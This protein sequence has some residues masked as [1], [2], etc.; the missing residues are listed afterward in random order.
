MPAEFLNLGS[1]IE[2]VEQ[3]AG[4]HGPRAAFTFERD[5]TR[6]AAGVTYQQLRDHTAAVAARLMERGRP[7]DRV[8]ILCPPGL[9]YVHAFL[10]SLMAGRVAVPAYPPLS[11]RA[12]GRVRAQL[13]DSGA[14]VIATTRAAARAL[15]PIL[16]AWDEVR[17]VERVHIDEV[18]AS[19]ASGWQPPALER[20]D[21]AFLQYTSGSTGDPR[22]VRVTHANLL[23]NEAMIQR[24]FGTDDHDVIL[25]WLPMFHDMG[26]LGM[27][28]T[29]AVGARGVLLSPLDFLRRPAHW[30]DAATRHRATVSG[31]PNFAYD[32]CARKITEA[33]LAGLDLS[34]WRV[35]Y[36]GAEPVRAGTLA[37]FIDRFEARGLRREALLPCYGMAE[38]TLLVA[39]ARSEEAPRVIPPP[40]A[41]SPG[42]RPCVDCGPPPAG[43]RCVAVD[44]ASGRALAPGKVGELWVAGPHVADGY[45]GRAEESAITFSARLENGEAPFLRT[46][47][48][49]FL[50]DD[51]HVVVTGRA[52]E[53]MIVRGANHHP[54]D[55]EQTVERAHVALR[56][57]GGAV[58]SIEAEDEERVVVVHEIERGA[59]DEADAVIAAVRRAVTEEHGIDAYAVALVRAGSVPRTSSG[60]VRRHACREQF[61][62]GTLHEIARSVARPVAGLSGGEADRRRH[63]HDLIQDHRRAV[64]ALVAEI[65]GAALAL[66]TGA[67]HDAPL[68]SLGVDSLTAAELTGAL[69][70][71]LGVHV[72]ISTILR[73]ATARDLAQAVLQG[74]PAPAPRRVDDLPALGRLSYGQQAL[75][76]HYCAAPT[77]SAYNEVF[78]AKV[79][80]PLDRCALRRALE[81]VL[82]RH[83][84]LRVR[85]ALRDG[86]PWCEP[87]PLLPGLLREVDAAGWSAT[88]LE[89][90]I[91]EEA[92]RPFALRESP[93][94]RATVYCRA[95][96][97]WA[98]CLVVHHIAV[99]LWSFAVVVDEL[100]A[101]Y[102]ALLDGRTPALPAPTAPYHRF[103]QREEELVGSAEGQRMRAYWER[104]LTP[105]PPRLRFTQ[106]AEI[107]LAGAAR[108]RKR[109]ERWP[110]DLSA[111]ARAFARD[112]ATTPYSVLLAA[113][114][115]FLHRITG[116]T[117]LLVGSPHANRLSPDLDGTV[118][119]LVNTLPMRADLSGRPTFDEHLERTRAAA[120]EALDHQAYP[121]ALFSDRLRRPDADMTGPF[122]VLFVFQR[123][124]RLAAEGGAGFVSGAGMAMRAGGLTLEPIEVLHKDPPADL[125][126]IVIDSGDS[127]ETVVLAAPHRVAAEV[128]DRLARWF[129]TFLLGA[130]RRPD[131]PLDTIPL[132]EPD[133]ERALVPAN[134]AGSAA[135]LDRAVGELFDEAA[136]ASPHAVAITGDAEPLHYGELKRQANRLANHLVAL[137]VRAG[138]RVAVL[139]DRSP[140]M[141]IALL[142]LC[143]AG[144]AY[145]PLDRANPAPRQQAILE[146]CGATAA[147]ARQDDLAEL[148][149]GLTGIDP[150]RD[151]EVIASR[152]DRAP[153]GRVLGAQAAYVMFTSGSTGTPKGVVVPHRAI[154]RLVHETDY[155]ELGPP[156]VVMQYAPLAF[157]ASTFEIWGALLTGATLALMPRGPLTPAELSAAIARHRVTTLW[158]TAALFRQA[159]DDTTDLFRGVR[160]VL[161]GGE[162]L[163]AEHVARLLAA[164]TPGG[165]VVVNGYGPTE[166]TTFTTCHR[167]TSA[168]P[169]SRFVPIGRPIRHTAVYVLDAQLRPLPPGVV[170]EI[171]A[172]GAGLA[173]GYLGQPAAT[174]AAFV[175]NPFDPR[176]SRLYRTGDIGWIGGDGAL[177]FVG[178]RDEQIKLRGFRIELSE[179]E[180]ALRRHPAVKDAV[181]DLRRDHAEEAILVAYVR[182]A[183][184]RH[185]SE[186]E[187]RE[188]LTR[189]LPPYMVPSAIVEV[190]ELVMTR[191]GKLDRRALPPPPRRE[192]AG[193]TLATPA[194]G[195]ETEISR[196]WADVLG[197]PVG[198]ET[199]FFLAGGHSLTATRV[200]GRLAVAPG[201]DVPLRT[202]FE[203][204]TLREFA[205]RVAA[206]QGAPRRETTSIP[207]ARR[208]VRLPLSFSQRR[209]WI[210]D[211]LLPKD[212]A[213]NVPLGLRLRGRLNADALDGAL[214]D[215]VARHEALRTIF[216]E[217]HGAPLQR[218][219]PSPRALLRLEQLPGAEDEAIHAVAADEAMVGFDLASDR[220]LRARLIRVAD[221]DH[222]L[223]LTLHHIAVDGWA[224][225]LLIRDLLT[226]YRGRGAGVDAGLPPLALQIA[227]YACWE[228]S[229]EGEGTFVESLEYWQRRLEGAPHVL[230][231]PSSHPRPRHQRHRGAKRRFLV[232]PPLRR[233]LD[234]LARAEH[235]TPFMLFLTAFNV[236]LHRLTGKTD[237][238][239]GTPVAGRA[240]PEIE[241]V[242]GCFVNTLVVRTSLVGRPTFRELVRRVA[243]S[244]VEDYAHQNAP[245]DRVVERL[246]V[247]RDASRAPLVQVMFALENHPV[248]P[249]DLPGI[250]ASLLTVDSATAK[251]DLDLTFTD[252]PE[253]LVGILEYDADLY[254]PSL[255]ERMTGQIMLIL[256]SLAADP[257]VK[258]AAVPLVSEAERAE[259]LLAWNRPSMTPA[260]LRAAPV[261]TKP[262]PLFLAAFDEQVARRPDALAAA[263]D[264]GRCTYRELDAR[265]RELGAALQASALGSEAV[266]PL[267]L[268]RSVD[269]LSG[270]LA[271]LRAGHA[272]LPLH[273]AHV[274]GRLRQIIERS[275]AAILLTDDASLDLARSVCPPGV[276]PLLVSAAGDSA[277]H[278]S[279][280]RRSLAY[281]VPTSGSTGVPKLVMVEHGGMA[282]HLEA[283]VVDLGLGPRDVVAQTAN[284]MSDVSIWQLLAPLTVGGSVSIVGD[285]VAL[286]PH[287]L[288]THVARDR[289]TVLELVPAHLKLVLDQV[290]A[291]P[292]AYDLSALRWCIATGEALPAALCARWLRL[293]PGVPMMNAY[294]PAECS[295]DVTHHVLREAPPSGRAIVPID[296]VISGLRLYVLDGRL[297]VVPTGG[298]GELF[299]GGVGVGR[300]YF[301][302]P[303]RT[304]LAFLPDPFSPAPGATMYRTGDLVRLAPD[305]R[306][307]FLGRRDQQMKIRGF[308]VEL[309][310]IEAAL[311]AHPAVRDVVVVADETD[312]DK[313]LIAYVVLR[314]SAKL[315]VDDLVAHLRERVADYMIP[316][317]FVEL[318]EL[319]LLSGG[320]VDRRALPAPPEMV[321]RAEEA[322]SG[323]DAVEE[324]LAGIWAN[325]LRAD[326][327]SR[328]ASFFELGGHSLLALQLVGYVR[329]AMGVELPL[330]T[331]FERPVLQDLAAEISGAL[332]DHAWTALP[333]IEPATRGG[334]LPVTFSQE[335]LY[336][337]SELD[338]EN[339]Q[340][341][342]FAAY[343][344]DGEL[345]LTALRKT[346]AALVRR[347]ESLRT[348]IVARQGRPFAVVDPPGEPPFD[349][350][351][352]AHLADAVQE[353][354]LARIVDAEAC[355]P[356]DLAAGPL[357]RVQLV[358]LR[359]GR[360]ALLVTVHHIVCDGLS[361]DV[362]L[363]EVERLYGD[364]CAGSEDALP[365]LEVQYLDFAAW[366]RDVAAGPAFA[367]HLDFWRLR[368]TPPPPALELPLDRPRPPAQSFRGAMERFTLPPH[369]TRGLSAFA[370]QHDAT[371]FMTLL[372]GLYALLHRV[373]GNE[374]V[375]IGT[376]IAGRD[377]PRTQ[378]LIG[379]FVNTLVLRVN[380][381][382][383]PSLVE[384]VARVRDAALDGYVHRHVPFER[385]VEALSPERD[386][387]R[388]PLFSVMFSL[389]QERSPLRLKG[390]EVTP[391]EVHTR[392]S[393][394]DLSLFV[395]QRDGGLALEAE[396]ATDLFDRETIV[397]LVGRYVAVLEALVAR[398][399]QRIVD[400]DLLLEDEA[401][402]VARWT[403]GEPGAVRAP[404]VHQRLVEQ[405]RATPDAVAIVTAHETVSYRELD[406]R[407]AKLA[408]WLRSEG[409]PERSV[410]GVHLPRSASAVAAI[411]GIL[412]AGCA[413]LILDPTHPTDRLRRIADEARA[414]MIFSASLSE[415]EG[416]TLAPR[417]ASLWQTTDDAPLLAASVGREDTAYVL[418]TSGST[419]RPKGVEMRHGPLADLIEWQV[420]Q[421]GR[422]PG[423]RTL[424][425]AP[426]GF[427]VSFQEIFATLGAG[428]ALVLLDEDERADFGTLPQRLAELQVT[429]LF[430]PFVALQQLASS[431]G[432]IPS[433]REIVT[434]GER[435][436]ITHALRAFFERHPGCRLQNQYGPTET[437]VVTAHRL[438]PAPAEWPTL[439]PIGRPL[440][441]VRAYL[442]DGRLR[443][444]PPG[445]AGEIHLGGECLARGYL[446][447]PELTAERFVPDPFAAPGGRMYRTGDRGRWLRGGEI[448]FLGRTD[449]QVKV[450]GHRVE[451]GEVEA[452]LRA[453][454]ALAD[455]AVTAPV[456]PGGDRRL[457]AYVVARD[458]AELSLASVRAHLLAT[459]PPYM[460]PSAIVPIAALPLTRSGKVDR[461][462]LPPPRIERDALAG[463]YEPPRSPLEEVL[464]EIWSEVLDFLRIG[465]RDS[466]FELG[467]HSLLATQLVSRIRE[468]FEIE[469]PLRTVFEAPTVERFAEAMLAGARDRDHIERTAALLVRIA[470]ITDEEA[471]ELLPAEGN[472]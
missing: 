383:A 358:A 307:E 300:G 192:V 445:V 381:S 373:T 324:L 138:D 462:A 281:V 416:L 214:C 175:P 155:V 30:L 148:G 24:A 459:L 41:S 109:R 232:D 452:A 387:S 8:L 156:H 116:E 61:E 209:L 65:A 60:K 292:D 21:L 185:A 270:V 73:G 17:T 386:L 457:V 211:R 267:L 333:P 302:E 128:A 81:L 107:E 378:A 28:H 206:L 9:D 325:L 152:T 240:W 431:D 57:G 329:A 244:L 94:F 27:L 407:S 85:V 377:D 436:T 45:W 390:L 396:Y 195:V 263:D 338:P 110:S 150:W 276:A 346:V 470:A 205:D 2:L 13:R 410:V 141:V 359:P 301:A 6:D 38:A 92:G 174:A 230:E 23:A 388:S 246:A 220:L 87:A 426:L 350:T 256:R 221:D 321:A 4:T 40:D 99:D 261:T 187:L 83:E 310:E 51:G 11:E 78:A 71:E 7:G 167:M 295:D 184:D 345:D 249:L 233:R 229:A 264:R 297:D 334:E 166:N 97:D 90:A 237:L 208:G 129:G 200:I 444:V 259:L 435:L 311:A 248:T 382:D 215:L 274:A 336:F 298:V 140:E 468:L 454:P 189:Q 113:F 122:D 217:E 288:L 421:S 236:W 203:A 363:R 253:G 357:L 31:G 268:H 442:L 278:G 411:V 266:V 250:E 395:I 439:P 393:K 119:Y 179:I 238:L 111:E 157:D 182:F 272:F 368:L 199:D 255:A 405:A 12:S 409:V 168:T 70:A 289:V 5:R 399:E 98:L 402:E 331:V 348:R 448:E 164:H 64:E 170:G 47:D 204:R 440:P 196:I 101:A 337:L 352:L 231:L 354:E 186:D 460:L 144:A 177:R 418:Y 471:E 451:I 376:P 163:S 283:K 447:Q 245:F 420:V 450:R 424:H 178:R 149:R 234:E 153:A 355:R 159:V 464:C 16:A 22:G 37:R 103:V 104:L 279:A 408:S 433:L 317:A 134:D 330:R 115:A 319:P 130:L 160:Q 343:Q 327:P 280:D 77:S 75:W 84:V 169:P 135:A 44:A 370:R 59:S 180:V 89:R 112:R 285:L 25:S 193:Q 114:Q 218:I 296:G 375:A 398:P 74:N 339:A 219:L 371:L 127:F 39:G 95:D 194:P 287:Q 197:V 404:L 241:E 106:P 58:F 385:I 455:A 397:R 463:D 286:D 303:D 235:V 380:L 52:K 466:F 18:P 290:E 251:F 172:A 188:S 360:H 29:I 183:P 158:M 118:G 123:L 46:G 425:F 394:F 20:R 181:V 428:G 34:A 212:P 379:F 401:K 131:A 76:F 126:W 136:A 224:M 412:R 35:A 314:G 469:L 400:L 437:H 326:I 48:L 389:Q 139:L 293:Y 32:L 227:D 265:A 366:Q 291:H 26:L 312:A 202:L 1:F 69:H 367:A 142:A 323:L 417:L 216:P 277:R 165:L 347:H 273:P 342:M 124:Q 364:F 415:I 414:A 91:D 62:R 228:Q 465:V 335:R 88:Q 125:T 137:G 222:L 374:E 14:T 151:R 305:G 117:D 269:F 257:D 356:F 252:A 173:H 49:G 19:A 344:I 176:D 68:T 210:L 133:E 429:R 162:V 190:S 53:V 306:L 146:A 315:R 120:A 313:R 430:L 207:R 161:A 198:P 102:S 86:E 143:K 340:Y 226:L 406:R 96:D 422:A 353:D 55:V 316:G 434:A 63:A 201:I 453:H 467:G 446:A 93:T 80:A 458:G 239:V 309:G 15:D 322:L 372:A 461:N 384:L 349:V 243:E 33:E 318:A 299:V 456:G 154:V 369:L 438:D 191:N 275:R 145:V 147:I 242:V 254:D 171:Y 443:S 260:E 427:D 361:L 36:C 79:S 66:P 42:A 43:S 328:R 441:G 341:N 10:G 432:C 449:D 258:V 419:G 72:P 362:M 67:P 225:S 294:G 284:Q 332:R 413:Y 423:E 105:P 304:A 391:T 320:K 213:Y 403:A 50:T 247:D 262:T 351:S 365:P 392:T 82:G 3:R 108:A 282:N 100:L 121:L 472:E 56:P 223:L 132:L 308:R 54:N 271:I